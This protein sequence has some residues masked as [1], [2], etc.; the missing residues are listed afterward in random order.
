MPMVL[1]EGIIAGQNGPCLIKRRD[2]FRNGVNLLMALPFGDNYQVFDSIKIK[3][4]NR[5]LHW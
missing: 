1:Q 2:G 5:G 3:D 4:S